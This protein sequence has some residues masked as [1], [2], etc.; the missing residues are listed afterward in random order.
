MGRK[1]ENKPRA[2]VLGALIA[3]LCWAGWRFSVFPIPQSAG[4][5][6]RA[7]VERSSLSVALSPVLRCISTPA[8]GSRLIFKAFGCFLRKVSD[9]KAQR[10]RCGAGFLFDVSPGVPRRFVTILGRVVYLIKHAPRR[11]R[12]VRG[13][14]NRAGFLHMPARRIPSEA[15]RRNDQT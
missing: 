15:Y 12:R 8:L 13:S 5:S 2:S 9:R 1:K 6:S 14:V 11:R 7:K 10:A 4:R 3:P